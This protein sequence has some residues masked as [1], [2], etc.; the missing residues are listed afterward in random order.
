[1]ALNII[2]VKF[3]SGATQAW[4]SDAWQNSI[5]AKRLLQTRNFNRKRGTYL[6]ETEEPTEA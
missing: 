2:T 6:K 4:A 3:C 5:V 1:M